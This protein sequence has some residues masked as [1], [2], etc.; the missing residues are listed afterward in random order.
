VLTR[1]ADVD[2]IIHAGDI[3]AHDILIALEAV[4]PVS[5]VWGNTDGFGM[6]HR[7]PETGSVRLGGKQIVIVHGHRFGVPTA[8][9]LRSAHP[10][11]DIVVYG[12]THQAAEDWIEGRLF[13]NPGSAGAPRNGRPATVAILEFH[14]GEAVAR[15]LELKE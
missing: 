6:R 1:F 3:G 7:L 11:A 2:H 12:H 10:D 14:E 8:A 15:I 5:A 4:A 9:L 13:L